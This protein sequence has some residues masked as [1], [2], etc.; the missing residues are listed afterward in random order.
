MNVMSKSFML[1][2]AFFHFLPLK[3]EGQ[4]E[5]HHSWQNGFRRT[6]FLAS[7]TVLLRSS[8]PNRERGS[9]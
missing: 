9:L 6:R 2:K 5:K 7:V 4:K 3:H 8:V 1:P